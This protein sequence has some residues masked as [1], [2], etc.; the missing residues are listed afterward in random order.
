MLQRQERTARSRGD[1]VVHDVIMTAVQVL[2]TAANSVVV[3]VVTA[4]ILVMTSRLAVAEYG[5]ETTG[6]AGKTL[7]TASGVSR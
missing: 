6:I 3:V 1:D 2:A 5:N 4:A 7:F